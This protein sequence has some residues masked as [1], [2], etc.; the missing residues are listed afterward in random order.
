MT[1]VSS[2]GQPPAAS[3]AEASGGAALR[4]N[5]SGMGALFITLSCLS[6]SIGVFIV[7]SDV[8]KQA[9]T[10]VFLCFAAA[11]VLGLAMASVYGE[12]ASAFP[13]TGGEYTILRRVLGP[14]W[15]FAVL[16]LNLLGF[17]IA[18]ALSGFGV[19]TYLAAVWPDL[20]VAPT[21]A[22]LVVLVT[23]TAVLNIR[24]NALVTG[25]FL[26][27]ELLALA[28]L[29]G[30]GLAHPHRSA[31]AALLHPLVSASGGGLGA[32]SLAVLGAATAGA[33]YAFNGYGAVVF[34]GEEMHEAPRRI[35]RVVF[36]ALGCAVVTELAPLAGVLVGVPDL[37]AL[38]AAQAPIPAAIAQ[39]A[40]P[41]VARTM[42]L[43]V[44]LAIFNAMIAVALMAGR[45]LYSTGRDGLWPAPVSLALAT[46]HP[47]F[48]SPWVATLVMGAFGLA[49]CFVNPHI[50]VLILGNGNV[51]IYAGLCLAALVGRRSGVTRHAAFKAPLFP[52]PPLF[53]LL[54]L[55]GVVG[56][57]L[58]DP[59]GRRGLAAT[60]IAIGASL[61]YAAV[62]ARARRR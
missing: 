26:A 28:V 3:A 13:E 54:F 14:P 34:L 19:A 52:L 20:P 24:I 57:D 2:L 25:V 4:R 58:I 44:A 5:M 32:P 16:G 39:L 48:G 59:A 55:A 51:A 61:A 53:G 17:S 6:P 47:R 1:K 42:S 33:I 10:G 56:F 23:A 30:L 11:A 18:Q 9:G 8:I 41:V 36:L 27:V 15:G 29:A 45:Q 62:I 31:A 35:A 37:H 49:A 60:V 46:V 21:A 43:A 22:V 50:L 7:G 40:G 38:D 12:L